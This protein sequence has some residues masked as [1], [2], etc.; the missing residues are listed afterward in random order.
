IYELMW[1]HTLTD[2]TSPLAYVTAL[3]VA[4]RQAGRRS[5]DFGAGV[6][7]GAVLFARHGFEVALADISST[8]QRFS[9][10]RLELRKLPARL[11]DLKAT[12]LPSDAFDFIT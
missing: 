3:Q 10:W 9:K 7:S 5:L 4:E 6:G 12:K 2:D 11:I 1:W 8:L